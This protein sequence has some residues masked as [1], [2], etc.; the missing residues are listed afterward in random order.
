MLFNSLAYFIFLPLVLLL[1]YPSPRR[2]Q[3]L[4]LLAA[5]PF[6]GRKGRGILKKQSVAQ[7]V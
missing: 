2:L 5:F 7:N 1:Y 3:N 6:L 4:I